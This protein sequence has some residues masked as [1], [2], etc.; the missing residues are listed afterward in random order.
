MGVIADQPFQ[1]LLGLVHDRKLD[2]WEVDIQKLIGIFAHRSSGEDLNM[3][4]PGRAILSASTLLRMKSD[5]AV[6]GD[7][8]P[9]GVEE[10]ELGF[11]FDLPNLGQVTVIQR[12]PR[13][14]TIVELLDAFAE[15]LKEVRVPPGS[16]KRR[17]ERIV[18]WLDEY[19]IN[20]EKHLEGLY[21]KLV[22]L[23]AHVREVAFSELP[24]ERSKIGAVRTFLLLLFLCARGKIALRQEEHFG[25]IFVRLR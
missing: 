14:I 21:S 12:S 20:I 16:K 11:D 1:I 13:K 5:A 25:D 8:Y 19:H 9:T 22:E 7:G 2:P 15:A 3:R 4:S 17:M 10:P 24:F 6:N 23:S 18:R